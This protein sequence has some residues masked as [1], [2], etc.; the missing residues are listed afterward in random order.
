MSLWIL[1]YISCRLSTVYFIYENIFLNSKN[2]IITNEKKINKNLLTLLSPHRW[3]APPTSIRDIAPTLSWFT[4]GSLSSTLLAVLAVVNLLA[5]FNAF[6]DSRNRNVRGS[7]VEF[8][9][10]GIWNSLAS[11]G[12]LCITRTPNRTILRRCNRSSS[13][14]AIFFLANY[15]NRSN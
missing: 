7:M 4:C 1:E 8:E 9:L 2:D 12:T 14:S 11:A 5:S 15:I 10:F 6:G 13:C 3:N